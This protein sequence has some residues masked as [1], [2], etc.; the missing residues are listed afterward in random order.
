M[1]DLRESNPQTSHT[2]R[3]STTFEVDKHIL[4]D[5]PFLILMGHPNGPLERRRLFGDF[6]YL[7]GGYPYSLSAIQNGVLRGNRRPPYQLIK[8][9]GPKDKRLPV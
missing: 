1:W 5:T 7:V 8:P 9:F 3:N 2:R 6:Q 4:F